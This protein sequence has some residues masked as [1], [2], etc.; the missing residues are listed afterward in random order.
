MPRRVRTH[1][2]DWNQND[3]DAA[4]KSVCPFVR[5]VLEHFLREEGE[6]KATHVTYGC[7]AREYKK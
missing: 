3:S 4:E 1:E 7:S 6:R 2:R 5:E